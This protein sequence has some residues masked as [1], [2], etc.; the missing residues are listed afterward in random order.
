MFKFLMNIIKYELRCPNCGGD[1]HK[2]GGDWVCEDCNYSFP[3]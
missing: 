1:M 3:R 2:V